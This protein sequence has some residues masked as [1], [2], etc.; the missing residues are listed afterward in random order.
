MMRRPMHVS[1]AT[2]TIVLTIIAG[3]MEFMNVGLLDGSIPVPLPPERTIERDV[4]DAQAFRQYLTDH[5]PK[6]ENRTALL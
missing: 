1:A 5:M 2:A 3:I 6:G 4:A